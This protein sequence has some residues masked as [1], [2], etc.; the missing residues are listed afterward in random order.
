M[1][2]N[3]AREIYKIEQRG[4]MATQEQVE[5]FGNMAKHIGEHMAIVAQDDNEKQRVNDWTKALT[6]M[7]N[8]VKGYAQRLAEQQKQQGPQLDA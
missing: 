2:T 3:M 8:M 7:M 1:L 5:G 4:S 6:K